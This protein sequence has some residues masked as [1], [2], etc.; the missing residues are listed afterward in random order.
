MRRWRS[1]I[2]PM[3]IALVMLIC[4]VALISKDVSCGSAIDLQISTVRGVSVSSPEA[5]GVLWVGSLII[6]VVALMRRRRQ[7]QLLRIRQ[8]GPG[9]FGESW[10]V[11]VRVRDD[12]Q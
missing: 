6:V 3:G 1:E 8:R 5:G 4:G 9:I 12:Q 7:N 2:F 11:E 10:V